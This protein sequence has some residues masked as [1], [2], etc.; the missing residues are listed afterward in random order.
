MKKVFLILL[1]AAFLVSCSRIAKKQ[2][3]LIDVEITRTNSLVDT[4]RIYESFSIGTNGD[5]LEWDGGLSDY[6]VVA[7]NVVVVKRLGK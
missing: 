2:F 5:L 1:A 7:K 6:S 4:I 3:Q